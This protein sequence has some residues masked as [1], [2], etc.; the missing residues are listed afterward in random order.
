MVYNVVLLFIIIVIIVI[1]ILYALNNLYKSN[2]V[3][4]IYQKAPSRNSY[5][6]NFI[7]STKDPTVDDQTNQECL[8]VNCEKSCKCICHINFHDLDKS[9]VRL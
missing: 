4:K 7:N 2:N 6:N 3:Y 8:C 5:P 1:I 9:I